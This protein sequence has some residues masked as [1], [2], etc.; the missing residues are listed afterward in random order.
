MSDRGSNRFFLVIVFPSILAIV[1]FILLTHI[2]LIPHFE[3]AILDKKKEMISELTN[4]AWSLL[5][6]Y[7]QEFTDSNLSQSEAQNIAALR[8][9]EIR[10]GHE[11]KDYFWIID[12]HP[13]M[14][15][16]PYRLELVNTDLSNYEDANGKK[17]FVEATKLV[18]QKGEG[19]IDYMWQWKDD[20][21][22]IVPKLSFVKEFVPWHWIIG[23]GIY[24]EDV[25]YE[26]AQLKR[27]LYSISIFI[28][29]LVSVILL[30]VVRQSLAI[31]NRRRKASSELLLSKEKY[32]SL[33]EASTEGTLMILENEIVFSNLKFSGLS[34]FDNSELKQQSLNSLF[35]VGWTELITRIDDPKKSLSIETKINCK[36]KSEKDVIISISKVK[37][38]NAEGY[39]I[40]TKE[41]SAK[42]QLEIESEHLSHELQ[43][44][45]LLMNQPIK[46]FVKKLVKSN[47][48]TTVLELA[49][50]MTAKNSKAVF[51][52]RN[53]KIVGVVN[54]S[55]IKKR[56][57]AQN[58]SFEKPAYEI[59]TAPVVCFSENALLYEAVLLFKNKNISHLGIKNDVGE[60]IG[61]ISCE[62]IFSIQQNAVSFLIK[63]IELATDVSQLSKINEKV[64]VLINAL[65]ESS[66][67]TENIT[68]IISSLTDSFTVK[69]I[70]LALED[71]GKP[72]CEFAFIALGSEG[73]KEQTLSTDQD[74]AIIIDDFG[75]REEH[76]AYFRKL[77]N[78]VCS[79]LN[80]VGYRFCS[81]EIMAQNPKWTQTLSVWKEYFSDWISNSEP[82]SILDA[83]IFFDFRCVYGSESIVNELRDYVN[84]TVKHQAVF[85]YNLALPVLKYKSPT[86]LFGNIIGRDT[87]HDQSVINVKKILLPIICF[88]R[89]YSLHNGLSETNTPNRIR[90]L[91]K[92]E[93]ITKIMYDELMLSY[94]YLMHLRFRFQAKSIMSNQFPG[95]EVV[96]KD[97]TQ[98]EISTLKKIFNEIANLQTKVNFDFK[99]NL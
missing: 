7:N 32:K 82:Q 16:H 2:I 17:L 33:V 55:D 61:A 93:I 62:D 40:I 71:L 49:K 54:D 85:F 5:E 86:N 37:Y 41:I 46:H 34:G 63:E 18:E 98:I 59:M 26:I 83:S 57:V 25:K 70:E 76:L 20:S 72:P 31:E 75:Q 4:T 43:T 52:T 89:L 96:V 90:K 91:Y 29:L 81:G 73:R 12:S 19:F 30:F 88:T 22:Q 97:L 38:A 8:I 35:Q 51:I 77:G 47:E 66:D 53:D 9:S 94:N 68:R 65:V 58:L 60:I 13:T 99:S 24:L 95:N 74:N 39:I 14:I 56:V 15:M 27:R 64:P 67:K 87:S 50:L 84:A 42:E 6:E 92:A 44:S 23:T 36:D 3:K 48:S 21:T 45:L 80:I 69:I 10:Y 11:L 78:R 79:D 1:L 28:S